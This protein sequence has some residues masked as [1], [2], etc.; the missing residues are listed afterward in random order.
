M[1]GFHLVD[2]D[3][4]RF[5]GMKDLKDTPNPLVFAARRVFNGFKSAEAS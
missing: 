2:S 1:Q 5:D 4:D 3:A